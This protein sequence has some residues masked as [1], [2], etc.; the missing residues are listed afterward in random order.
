M[1][2]RR[3]LWRVTVLAALILALLPVRPAA[4]AQSGRPYW[5]TAAWQTTTPE[6]QG[7]DSNQLAA[8]LETIAA[9]PIAIDSVLV[10][11]HGYL[12]LEAYRAPY[13]AA[14]KHVIY[15]CTKSVT[16]ALIGIAIE[17]GAIGG[18]QDRVLDYFPDR[19]VDNLDDAKQSLTLEHLLTMSSGLDWRGGM[20]EDTFGEMRRSRDWVQFVLDRPLVHS[21]GTTYTYNTGGSHLL[22]AIL[23][24]ATGQSVLDYA[25]DRLFGPLGITAVTWPVDSQ[26][27]HTGGSGLMLTPRDMAK[28][29]YLYLNGGAWDGQQI[30]P[31]DWV[32][33]STQAHIAAGGQWLSDG[34]GYQWWVDDAG[35][36]MALGWAGQYIVLVPSLDMVV[37]FTSDLLPNNFFAPETLLNRAIMPA[38]LADEPLPANPDGVARLEAAIQALAGPVNSVPDLATLVSGRP[39]GLGENPLGWETMVL[40]VGAQA[41]EAQIEINGGP[42]APIGLDGTPRVVPASQF[43]GPAG[44]QVLLQGA[45]EDDRTFAFT[46]TPLIGAGGYRVVALFSE[47]GALA[48]EFHDLAT[49]A[50]TSVQATHI[51]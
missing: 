5:P 45:W 39:Y 18:V 50:V 33:T 47:D 49:D 35:Y 51:K 12:V 6:A 9:G 36:V 34:Y 26:G 40:H 44:S 20:S 19:R 37:V 29:G 23:R 2:N 10:V 30:V 38:A 14:E 31:A 24:H 17:E 4:H 11:R 3:P 13:T 46:I 27:I 43:G 41:A 22:A 48:V 15:S 32:A 25:R 21:P 28:F 42:A 8:M 16:S 7:M 1:T